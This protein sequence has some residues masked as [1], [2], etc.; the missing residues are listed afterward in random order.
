MNYTTAYIKWKCSHCGKIEYRS[1][2][3]SGPMNTWAGCKK[4]I[5]G[6]GIMGRGGHN[7]VK[8]GVV[9]NKPKGK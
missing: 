8:A 2:L 6:Q 9:Q 1:T 4:G 7:W 5:S 3:A